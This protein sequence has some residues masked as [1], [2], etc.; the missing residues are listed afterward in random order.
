[1]QITELGIPQCYLLEPQVFRDIRGNFVK[2]FVTSLLKR[3]GLRTD[4]V[5]QYY[6]TSVSGVVRGMHFQV[7]PY[8]HAKLV[9]CAVGGVTDV[10]LDLR[11]K[12]PTFGQYLSVDLSADSGRAIYIESGVAH[13]FIVTAGPALL[14]YNVTS[15]YAS[16]HDA[17]VR[18]DSFGF[19][20]GGGQPV[21]SNRDKNFPP[22][23]EFDTPF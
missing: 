14:V 4:F 16:Q 13:G 7:P 17:G 12:S 10:L 5:E 21:I 19:N 2:P 6:S 23:C 20:W 9:Y 1:M 11:K 8:D 18:W 3:R 22:L 15:E